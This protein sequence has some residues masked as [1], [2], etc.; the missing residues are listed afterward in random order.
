MKVIARGRVFSGREN[1]DFQSCAFSDICVL[2]GGRWLCAFRAAPE[3][4][5][6]ASQHVLMTWSDD[7]GGSWSD[8]IAPFG[9][10]TSDGKPGLFRRA[11]P[12]ALG[13]H[14]VLACICWVDHSD[15]SLPFFNEDTEGL[16]DTRIFLARSHDAGATW[17]A[18]KRIATSPFDIPTPLTGP[19][20]VLPGGVLAC[21][22]ETNK[23]YYDTT[24][25]RHSSV[26]SFSTDDGNS[27]PEH[28]FTSRTT[29]RGIF[30]WDQRPRVLPDGRILDLFWTYDNRESLYLNIHARESGGNGRTWSAPWDTGVPG[31]PAPPVSLA[32]GRIGMVYVDRTAEPVIKMRASDDGGRTWPENSELAISTPTGASQTVKKTDMRDAWA[33]MGAFSIGLPE[34]AIL[35][36]GDILVV[37]YAGP[38]TDHT[39]IEWARVSM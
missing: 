14:E 22:F 3:K 1:T 27:W 10:A 37:Y 11:A 30:Y 35:R 23:T 24:P 32:D 12:T 8:A 28:V 15:S 13:E 7:E 34:T 31:Q 17:S 9:P 2:P 18:P 16:L 4:L 29:E 5:A 19:A 39:N 6:T 26:L 25:W 36:N 33:E 38:R 20:L 21:Q